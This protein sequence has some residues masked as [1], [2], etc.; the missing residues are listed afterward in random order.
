MR[1]VLRIAVVG[2]A[3]AAL[4]YGRDAVDWDAF[5]RMPEEVTPAVP[6]RV[7]PAAQEPKT[8]SRD[9][10]LPARKASPVVAPPEVPVVMPSVL[11][12]PPPQKPPLVI[13]LDPDPPHAARLVTRV[14]PVYPPLARQARMAGAVVIEGVV[15]VQGHIEDARVVSGNP[16]LGAAA[17]DAVRQWTYEP[18]RANGQYVSSPVRVTVNFTL[19][20]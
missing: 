15:G 19:D 20:R 17:L 3:A 9:I 18:A 8:R 5:W 4:Y 14:E 6:A 7:P 1:A 16:V 2:V 11:A 10:N 13:P 12:A